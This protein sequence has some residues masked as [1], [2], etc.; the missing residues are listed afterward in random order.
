MTEASIHQTKLN[1]I[2]NLGIRSAIGIIFI[3]HGSGKLNPGFGGFLTGQLGFP[4]EMQIPIA[5]AEIIP[6]I[7]LIVGIFTRISASMLAIVMLG[8][9]FHVKKAANLT[10]EGGVEFELILLAG[11][12]VI[13]AAGPGRASLAHVIKK[14]PRCL[15]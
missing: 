10:G 12:L 8:A 4:P 9:I 5:L 13:V 1:D 3:V 6:G 2:T 15:H 14:L 7:L 11:S